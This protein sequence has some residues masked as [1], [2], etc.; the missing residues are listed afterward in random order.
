MGA[1]ILADLKASEALDFFAHLDYSSGMFN[2]TMSHMP[3]L[4]AIIRIGDSAVPKLA[5]V[6]RQNPNPSMRM[7][8]VYC[9]SAI[10]GPAAAHTLKEAMQTKSDRCVTVFLRASIEALDNGERKVLDTNNWFSAFLCRSQT[11]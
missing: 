9:I 5:E 6:L 11:A 2:T 4:T 8:S 1:E 7:Y 10:G 3:M